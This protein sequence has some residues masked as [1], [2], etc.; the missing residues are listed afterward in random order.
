MTKQSRLSLIRSRYLALFGAAISGLI[1]VSSA[2][3]AQEARAIRR[4]EVSDSILDE[5]LEGVTPAIESVFD[6]VAVKGDKDAAILLDA[7]EKAR[8]NREVDTLRWNEGRRRN[9]WLVVV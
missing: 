7:T 2:E 1:P 3:I 8:L 6:P 9:C 4:H 5:D